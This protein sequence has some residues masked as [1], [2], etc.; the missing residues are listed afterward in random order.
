VRS[1]RPAPAAAAAGDPLPRTRARLL[2][3]AAVLYARAGARGATTR[4]L[5]EEAGVDEAVIFRQ[6]GSKQALLA[7]AV[8]G[9][10]VGLVAPL[11]A[12]PADPPRELAAWCAAQ[13]AALRRVRGVLRRCA[14]DGDAADPALAAVLPRAFAAVAAELRRYAGRLR[15]AGHPGARGDLWTRTALVTAVLFTDALWDAD[16]CRLAWP[17]EPDPPAR[18]AAALLDP[19]APPAGAAPAGAGGAGRAA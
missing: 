15:D 10:L 7:E 5:A 13:T 6:F 3:A 8:A 14:L 1:V 17:P 12:A 18:L 2:A 19:C 16:G 9:A 11:P 4:R